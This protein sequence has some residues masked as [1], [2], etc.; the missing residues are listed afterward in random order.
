MTLDVS[1]IPATPVATSDLVGHS[2]RRLSNSSDGSV[3]SAES[4]FSFISA[5]PSIQSLNTNGSIFGG[6]VLGL[7]S[8]SLDGIKN[9]SPAT[10]AEPQNSKAPA[11]LNL[12]AEDTTSAAGS[13]TADDPKSPSK[14][15]PFWYQYPGFEPDPRAPFKHELGRLC[16]HLGATMKKGKKNLQAEALTAEIKYHYGAHMNRLDRWQELCEEVGI[17]KI[18]TSITQCQKVLKPVFVNLFNLVDHRRNP[19]LKVLRFQSYGEFNK[20]TRNGHKFPLNCAKQEGFIKIL[21]KR[22]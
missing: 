16:K 14:A 13:G 17:E 11:T 15:S 2:R 10:T 19:E 3:A 1:A 5:A 12:S 21:L 9:E 6:I 18:P 4:D 7:E 8:V 22:V 20:F